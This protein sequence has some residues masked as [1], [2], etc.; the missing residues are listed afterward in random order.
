MSEAR[1]NMPIESSQVMQARI[2]EHLRAI[3]A[4]SEL[5]AHRDTR[6]YEWMAAN[7]WGGSGG[8]RMGE[9]DIRALTRE[10]RVV[11]V[12]LVGVPHHKR[13]ASNASAFYVPEVR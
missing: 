5:T 2:V 13:P 8:R 9:T 11:R 7:G 6:L 3:G 10:G 1:A 12:D 4:R